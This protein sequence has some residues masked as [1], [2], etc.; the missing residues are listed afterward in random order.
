[1]PTVL[2]IDASLSMCRPV[3]LAD[4]PEPMQLR[5]LAADGLNHLLQYMAIHCKL[6]F[7]SIVVFS[8]LWEV[9]EPFTRD[10]DALRER[11]SRLQ[12][13][14]RTAFEA[15]IEGA[16]QAVL[17][18]WGVT[19]SCQVILVTDGNVPR[20]QPIFTAPLFPFPCKLHVVPLCQPNTN[21]IR[22]ALPFYQRLIDATG[23]GG[24]VVPEGSLT[25]K[26]VQRAFVSIGESSYVSWQGRLTCGH[27]SSHVTLCPP[28]EPQ[29]RR[30]PDAEAD[31]PP[32][33]MT[34]QIS[35]VGFMNIGDVAHPAT[36]S[37]HLVLPIPAPKTYDTSDSSGGIVGGIDSQENSS[38]LPSIGEIKAEPAVTSDSGDG[39]CSNVGSATGDENDGKQASF[40]VLL[41]GSLKVE[42]MVAIARIGPSWYGMLYSWA[43]SKK[44]SNLML[45]TFEPG[46]N[47]VPWWCAFKNLGSA[48]LN[49]IPSTWEKLKLPLKP[50]EK[51]SYSQNSVVWIRTTG[52]QADIQKI[53]RHARKLPEKIHNFYK[54]L[55]RVRRAAISY[56][57]TDLLEALSSILE[58]ECTLLP[59]TAHPDAA[60]QLS[61]AANQLKPPANGSGPL[62]DADVPI[63]PLRT[64]YFQNMSE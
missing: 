14:D 8:S 49:G 11:L 39:V 32:V 42:S 28:P 48:N 33:R 58:R 21:Q 26:S 43:D 7:C 52:L 55:N 17:H 22:S 5:H 30:G 25:L 27:L 19:C 10:F 6:E 23:A 2:L 13:Y 31:Q 36:V 57:F 34:E 46:E 51:P 20:T 44:K 54:E 63:A 60:L 64:K 37:R 9:V 41:H 15:G 50:L 45:S 3:E 61:H 18:E 1:M 24:V 29:P 56:G 12:F 35:I 59:G 38:S 47:S 16:K 53:L 40:C 4:R 62:P